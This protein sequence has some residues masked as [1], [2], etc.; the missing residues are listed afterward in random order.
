MLLKTASVAWS[1]LLNP[2][3]ILPLVY[4]LSTHRGLRYAS[5]LILKAWLCWCWL[6]WFKDLLRELSLFL[7]PYS[8]L[9]PTPLGLQLPM[10]F[11]LL[12]CNLLLVL[13]SLPLFNGSMIPT[14]TVSPRLIW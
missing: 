9:L 2:R 1:W 4:A 12:V 7:S 11:G 3:V 5:E 10:L 13:R 14:V 6:V 8:L